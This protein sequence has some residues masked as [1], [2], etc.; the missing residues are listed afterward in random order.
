MEG[1]NKENNPVESVIGKMEEAKNVEKKTFDYFIKMNKFNIF[2]LKSIGEYMKQEDSTDKL[3][4]LNELRDI[5]IKLTE[6]GKSYGL[7]EEEVK[8]YIERASV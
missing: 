2:K 5:E 3:V 4:A 1:L 6:T 7:S 8:D